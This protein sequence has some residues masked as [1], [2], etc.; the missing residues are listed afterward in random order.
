MQVKY[1]ENGGFVVHKID[2]SRDHR[3]S[4]WFD[5]S[6]EPIDAERLIGNRS[7]H[8]SRTGPTWDRCRDVGRMFARKPVTA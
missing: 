6:G 8:I 3:I 2:A 1:F 4:A 5:A 7:Y